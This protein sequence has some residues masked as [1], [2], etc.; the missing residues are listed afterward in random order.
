M[1][2][3]LL[4]GA[5]LVA[6]VPMAQQAGAAG[7]APH[8]GK[9]AYLAVTPRVVPAPAV[10]FTVN[11]TT[12]THDAT[13]GDGICADSGGNCS[14]RAAVEEA[15]ALQQ[16]VAVVVPAGT[17]SLTIGTLDT[18]DGAGLVI[19]GAGAG[20]TIIDATAAAATAVSVGNGPALAGAF[21]QLAGVTITGGN[22]ANGAGINIISSNDTAELQGVTVTHNTA[23]SN[24]GGVSVSGNLWATDSTFSDN[25]ADIGG[26]IENT[27]A[28]MRITD[29][30]I[31]GNTAADQGGG[32]DASDG[33]S[34]FTGGTISNNTLTLSGLGGGIYALE[35]TM[36]GTTISGN[37]IAGAGGS[38]GAGMYITYGIGP[39]DHLTVTNNTIAAGGTSYGAGI[40]DDEGATITNSIIS[41]NSLTGGDGAGI[42]DNLGATITDTIVS[43]NTV[44][45]GYGGGIYNS[46][47]GEVLMND[48]FTGN[49]A[50][51]GAGSGWGGGLYESDTSTIIDTL[52]SNNHADTGAGGSRLGP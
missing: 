1:G 24:G 3:S 50:L 14:L 8:A 4:V 39:F 10:T 18:A 32:V 6:T 13:A 35:T 17:Y 15:N 26:G 25:T 27:G 51:N 42:Y 31:T 49:Q 44:T 52:I 19:A 16:T 38:S 43:D 11:T 48:S 47:D 28:N 23:T 21:T 33:T 5:A 20:A 40:F 46:G 34:V 2:G 29:C 41:G 36:S 30:T 22:S 7:A 45:E 37:S 9:V 12:D